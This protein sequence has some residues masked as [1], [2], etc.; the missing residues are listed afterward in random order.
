PDATA[1]ARA[2]SSLRGEIMGA[3][4]AEIKK[5]PA[6]RTPAGQLQSL[7][8]GKPEYG[9]DDE[10]LQKNIDNLQADNKEGA[11]IICK[12]V[13]LSAISCKVA[14]APAIAPIS[15]PVDP[16]KGIEYQSGQTLNYPVTGGTPPYMGVQW[17]GETPKCFTAV[18]QSPN[19][20]VLSPAAAGTKCTKGEQ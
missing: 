1:L 3:A 17:S 11:G 16:T 12:D 6:R 5:Q 7:T 19:M 15:L 14:D 13:R 2:G 8:R 4:A 9:K 10:L 18:I 20:L